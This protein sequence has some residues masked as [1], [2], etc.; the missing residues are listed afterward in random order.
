MD[1]NERLK[2]K[3]EELKKNIAIQKK[4]NSDSEGEGAPQKQKLYSHELKESKLRQEVLK[5]RQI[6]ENTKTQQKKGNDYQPSM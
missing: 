3:I 1:K 5:R 2:Q 4:K 6:S